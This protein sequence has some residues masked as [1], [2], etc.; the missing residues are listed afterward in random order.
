MQFMGTM[1]DIIIHKHIFL[2]VC[3][4]MTCRYLPILY[5]NSDSGM[6]P[7]WIGDLGCLVLCTTP[8]TR[9]VMARK[10]R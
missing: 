9:A 2:N 5:S 8:T 1:N 6:L 7:L 4:L 3:L 10:P